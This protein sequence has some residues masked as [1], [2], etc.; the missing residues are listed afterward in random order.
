[1]NTKAVLVYC[2]A[3]LLGAVAFVVQHE[4]NRIEPVADG[5]G[6]LE[7]RH[8][9]GPVPDEDDAATG[10]DEEK[11]PQEQLGPGVDD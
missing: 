9:E 5:G 7:A 10:S 2:L 3:M 6:E 11:D 1:M 8:L 4:D